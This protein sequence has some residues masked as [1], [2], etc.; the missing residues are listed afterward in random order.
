MF[1][2][3]CKGK[4]ICFKKPL[5]MGIINA[6]P[7]SFYEG[8]LE[9]GFESILRLAEKMVNERADILDIGGQSTRPGSKKI[10]EDEEMERVLPVIK[11]IH[12]K[13][14]EILISIDTYYSKVAAK[15]VAEGA[16]I[17]NDISAG[18]MDAEMIKTVAAL[19]VPYICMHMKGT[20]QS[21]SLIHI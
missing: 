20:P 4:L 17:V 21:L 3:N 15:A 18:N 12:D 6:T 10:S 8:H 13:F 1:T 7:D 16:H 11:A 9:K 14:P 2:L 5:V 19:K